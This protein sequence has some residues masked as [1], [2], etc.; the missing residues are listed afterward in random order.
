VHFISEIRY[1]PQ[2]GCE[3]KYYR[4]KETFRDRLGKVHSR[5]MLNVGFLSGFRPED[6]RDI[7]KGLTYLYDHQGEQ[8]VFSNPFAR[9]SER[10]QEHIYKFWQ[11]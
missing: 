1:N 8:E 11:G 4:I 9:Y 6:I 3:A 7:G 10:V 5:I 2:A